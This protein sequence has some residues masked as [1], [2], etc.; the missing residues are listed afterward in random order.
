MPKERMKQMKQKQKPNN[1]TTTMKQNR[2]ITTAL[3]GVSLLTMVS[4]HAASLVINGDFE[5]TPPGY[6]GFIPGWEQV[7]YPSGYSG[8]DY[9]SGAEGWKA[10]VGG[11]GAWDNGY[12]PGTDQLTNKVAFIETFAGGGGSVPT[13]SLTQLVTGFTIGQVY[14]LS[15]YENGRANPAVNTPTAKTFVGG[16]SVVAAHLVTPVNSQNEYS[17]P[18]HHRTA[19]FT[20]TATQMLLE[21]RATQ[22]GVNDTFLLIDNV[23]INAIPEPGSALLGGLGLLALL[24]R[25]RSA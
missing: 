14:E 5:T 23:A 17:N 18:F 25:R 3:L 10:S 13:L 6:Y 12:V 19:Q 20:A 4:A 24:R 22:V 2:K 16:V 1:P 7:S 8:Y 15:Y 11:V 9:L 21:F